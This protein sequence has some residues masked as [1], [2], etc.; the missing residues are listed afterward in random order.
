M[1]QPTVAIVGVG[2]IG[3]S[4][5]LAWRKARAAKVIGIT[6]EQHDLDLALACGAVDEGT[7]DLS[8]GVAAADVVVLCTPVLDIVTLARSVV[9]YL[10]PGTLLTDVGSTKAW[11]MREIT[12]F[13]P[14]SLCFIGGHPIAGSERTGVEAAD[15]YLFENAIYCLT[16]SKEMTSEEPSMRLLQG[17]VR[18]TGAEPVVLAPE[19]HD[20]IVAGISH[21]PH[22][23]AAA[24]VNSVATADTGDMLMLRLA[25]GGFRDTTRIASGSSELWRDICLTN[26][27][28][29]AEMLDAF[30]LSLGLM[31]RAVEQGQGETL[32]ELLENARKARLNLPAPSGM[33][34]LVVTLV[35]QPGAIH[36]VTGIIARA[37]LNI[38]DIGILRAR[39]GDGGTMRLV[40]RDEAA[41]RA[42]D[43]LQENGY[44]VRRRT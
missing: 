2:L 30:E 8:Q 36:A 43:L 34:E 29:I 18:A 23:V 37:D 44:E 6:R 19:T 26:G 24:L 7:T 12:S 17:L 1:M 25:A 38:V 11:I 33:H 27:P 22:L 28:A 20:L 10:R 42:V 13:L 16:P 32:R 5:G 14:E 21:V 35:D 9:P 40:L 3:G 39:E 15:P 41:D 31:R 4:L